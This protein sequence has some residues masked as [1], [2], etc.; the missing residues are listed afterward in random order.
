[1]EKRKAAK[2]LL[3]Y[4]L[5]FW[6]PIALAILL[7]SAAIYAELMGPFIAKKMIDTHV[8]GIQKAWYETHST[9][10]EVVNFRG[11]SYKREDHFKEGEAKGHEVH[12]LQVGGQFVFI[13]E[14]VV[15]EGKRTRVGQT[16]IVT[17]EDR[18]TRY[19][20]ELLSASEVYS[21]FKPEISSL[22][23]LALYYFGLLILSS[24]LIFGQ[25]FYLQ[26][27][28]NCIIQKMREDLF[29]RLQRLSIRYF[30][31]QLAGVTVSRITN[32]TEAVRELYVSVLANFFTVVMHMAAI[33]A[34]LFIL[35]YRLALIVLPLIPLL[36]VWV[37][38]YRR[39]AENYN[40]VIRDRLGKI[41]AKLNETIQGMPIIQAYRRE[42]VI[43]KQFDSVNQQHWVYQNKLL[44]LNAIT[45]HNLVKVVRNLLFVIVIWFYFGDWL[46]SVVTVGVLYAFVDYVNRLTSPIMGMINQLS[47]METALVSAYRVFELFEEP[48]QQEVA[49]ELQ[50]RYRGNIRFEDVW[51]AYK[52]D[53]YVLKGISFEVKEGQ[54]IALIGH[55]GSG[56]SSVANLLLRYYDA[57]KGS[58]CIDGRDICDIPVKNLRTQMGIVLQDPFLFTGTI[59]SNISLMEHRITVEKAEKALRDVGAA[60]MINQLPNGLLEPVTENGTT[61]SS[62]QRQLISFARALAF[63]PS[64]L[65][66]DEATSNVD[67]ETES[68][69]QHALQVLKEGRTTILIAH[70]MSTIK[71][72]DLILVLDQGEIKESGNHQDLMDLKGRYYSMYMVQTGMGEAVVSNYAL[73]AKLGEEE[74]ST[75]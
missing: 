54:T 75:A 13:N 74:K 3:H 43:Q 30:D 64:I 15:L 63:D 41:H 51:F 53:E 33:V 46:G 6:K 31:N 7:L 21:F 17:L 58:I 11:A 34:A 72:A 2:R 1:M 44:H 8:L 25:R 73:E 10:S 18:S 32:D 42:Q 40:H 62:G 5:I 14:P 52:D 38:V 67:S 24:V 27:A 49:P 59:Y 37:I 19:P 45:S 60:E 71:S 69:I 28:A 36:Y 47:N 20:A 57:N 50:T 12:I 26:S 22:L 55:T 65:I 61:L 16:V 29:Q 9:G 56:K 68:I 35:N 4:A 48:A 70:R 39:F 23:N 66:L